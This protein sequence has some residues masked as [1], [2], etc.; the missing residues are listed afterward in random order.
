[1]VAEIIEGP[2]IA[3]LTCGKPTYLVVLLHGPGKA[4]AAMI[5]HALNWAPEMPK[6][7]FLAIE[8]PF[9]SAQ[10]AGRRWLPAGIDLATASPTAVREGLDEVAPLLHAFLD[11]ALAA[12]RLPDSHLALVGFSEGAMLALHAGLRREKPLAAIVA[13]SGALGEGGDLEAELRSSP[14]TLLIHGEDDPVFPF[15]RMQDDK[16]RLKALGVPVKSMRRPGLG[17]AMDDDGI[18]AAGDFLTAHVTHKKAEAPA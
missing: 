4:G 12:R 6:A 11:Q 2:K 17:H 8:A 16:A 14:P 3:A 9:A 10:E 7:D 5:H 15:A 18:I 13:F 1:M